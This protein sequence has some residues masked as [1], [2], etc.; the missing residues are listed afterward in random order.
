MWKDP[1]K[2]TPAI[3]QVDFG[4]WGQLV[5]GDGTAYCGPTSLVMAL[6]WLGAN[7]FTQ[8]APAQ[9][10]DQDDQAT[11]N[12]ELLIAGLMDTSSEAGTNGTLAAGIVTYL[13]A[14][15]IA[16]AQYNYIG[17]GNPDLQWLATQLAPNVAQDPDTIVLADF[18]VGWYTPQQG[19]PTTL[20]NV[21][22]HVLCPLTVDLGKGTLTLN[23]AYPASF[24]NVTNS[25]KNSLQTVEISP[26]PSQFTLGWPLNTGG[27]YSEVISGNKGSGDSYAILWGA[28]AWAI[29][30]SALP[31]APNYTI[32]PWQI[33]VPQTINTNGAPFN[34]V[35][36]LAG[37]GGLCKCGEG[38][39]TLTNADQFTGPIVVTGGTLATTQSTGMP[40]GTGGIALGGGSLALSIGSPVL[41][42]Q[43]ASGA[44]ALFTLDAG[45]G[46]LELLG[47]SPSVVSIGSYT[48]GATAN[49]A[50]SSAGTLALQP[51][52]GIGGLGIDQQ[53]LVAGTGGNLPPVSNGIVAPWILGQDND[54]AGSGAFLTYDAGAGG[55]AAADTVSSSDTGIN[56][57]TGG[58]VYEV[59]DEQTIDAGTTVQAAALEM[60]G[61]EIGGAT[62]TLQ[63][64]SQAAGDVAGLIMN[65]GDID[66]GTL[67]FGAAEGVIYGSESTLGTTIN[68]TISGSGGLTLFGPGG[69][70]LAA[71]NSTS[72]SGP[73]NVNSGTLVAAGANG[74]TGAGDV[75]VNS[76]ATLAVS[77][78]VSGAVTVGQSATLY[79]YGGTLQGDVTIAA[80]GQSSSDPGGTLQ[81]NGTLNGTVTAAGNILSGVEPGVLVFATG[82]SLPGDSA[83]YWRLQGLVDDTTSQAGVGWNALQIDQ[84]SIVM[85]NGDSAPWAIFLDFSVLASGDPDDGDPFWTTAHQW[86]LITFATDGWTGN[87]EP[88]NGAYLSGDFGTTWD[89]DTGLL[90]YLTWTPAPTRR[91]PAERFAAQARMRPAGKQRRGAA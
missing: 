64:G 13:S 58:M 17:S 88:G 76:N 26:V 44:N 14:C 19:D 1:V 18:S 57:V 56:G 90:L 5:P 67:S 25:P 84:Q 23:N 21:G 31:T 46:A 2:N 77:G 29:S 49:L 70:T 32:S 71:D 15:G 4:G 50:R 33:D 72:L 52:L 37:A 36:P 63:V 45:G 69:V 30:S 16:P 22:G 75:T 20:V 85:G 55:F 28:D 91:T 62:A 81:G 8:L 47:A 3:V 54:G 41:K 6:Y 42:V 86:T 34:V 74:A 66:A 9:F 53:V 89:G 7:G 68:S 87:W 40:F 48:D 43:I 12:L 35:A 38:T 79:L 82:V 73:I 51:N 27:P 83:F 78:T 80:I 61:G 24:E 39:M 10:G 59:V 65:G 11:I 60:N